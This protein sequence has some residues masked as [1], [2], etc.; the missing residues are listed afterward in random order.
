LQRESDL[1]TK[2]NTFA[3]Y[4]KINKDAA[5]DFIVEAIK[6]DEH[7]NFG[8]VLQL[9]ILNMIQGTILNDPRSS[10]RLLKIIRHFSNSRFNSV[11]YEVASTLIRYTANADS[12]KIASNILQQIMKNNTDNNVKLLVLD[13]LDI[14]RKKNR[15][16]INEDFLNLLKLAFSSGYE[17]KDKF[18]VFCKHFITF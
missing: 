16:V 1:T 8:D 7:E 17:I 4:Y 11:L 6:D 12:F 9:V 10:G 5:I 2:R 14:I 3:L 18:L 13:Q 15:Q